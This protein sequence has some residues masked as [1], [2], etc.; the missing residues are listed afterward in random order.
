M[1]EIKYLDEGK[2][3][4]EITEDDGSKKFGEYLDSGTT[5]L[6]ITEVE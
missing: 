4:F 6:Q 1:T 3:R 2:T 5:H